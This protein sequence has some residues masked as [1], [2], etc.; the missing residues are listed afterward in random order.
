MNIS[1]MKKNYSTPTTI[2]VYLRAAGMFCVS[3]SNVSGV[4]GN[5][6]LNYGGG[7][8]TE[9]MSREG[10]WDEEEE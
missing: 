3:D 2:V 10:G 8:T 1:N 4:A 6:G 5:A 9:A 7:S